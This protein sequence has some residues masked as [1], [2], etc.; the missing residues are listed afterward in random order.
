MT[1]DARSRPGE[2]AP[3]II[4]LRRE[5][6]FAR[7]V[8]QQLAGDHH[9][10]YLGRA[11]VDAQRPDFAVKLFDLDALVMPR[12]PCSCTAR[13]ITRCAASVAN[14]FAIAASRV[15]RAAPWSLVQAAR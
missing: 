15:T 13:S 5:R 11:L 7:A 14:I 6:R 10:L 12:P 9:L 1:T 8:L 4:L 3:A 2:N